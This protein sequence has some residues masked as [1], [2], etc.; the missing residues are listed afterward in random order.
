MT[1]YKAHVY[2][3]A[4]R[5][6]F[7]CVVRKRGVESLSVEMEVCLFTASSSPVTSKS[8]S[9]AQ[10]VVAAAGSSISV[11]CAA[12]TRAI[13][14]WDYYPHG[15]G[16]TTRRV[17][18]FNGGAPSYYLDPRFVFS[19]CQLNNC[20]LVIRSLQLTDAGRFLCLLPDSVTRNLSL[21]VLGAYASVKIT[22]NGKINKSVFQGCS[23]EKE[24]ADA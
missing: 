19:G 20:S 2:D 7:T 14:A 21:S 12:D 17:T 16:G 1:A 23:P 18:L 11:S 15:S 4:L 10:R 3:T 5:V 24:V 6:L 22:T 9:T 13:Q 8:R